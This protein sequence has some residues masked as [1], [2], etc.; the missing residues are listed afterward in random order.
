MLVN[1]SVEVA[2]KKEWKS[3]SFKVLAKGGDKEEGHQLWK[4]IKGAFV[5]SM[6]SLFLLLQ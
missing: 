2:L 1:S 5:A 6:L 3:L 4:E